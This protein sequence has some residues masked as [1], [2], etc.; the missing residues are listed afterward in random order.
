[1]QSYVR[2]RHPP[3]CD[4]IHKRVSVKGGRP[5]F[6]HIDVVK[7]IVLI[8][9][10]RSSLSASRSILFVGMARDRFALV[11]LLVTTQIRHNREVSTATFNIA[12][13]W[14]FTSM[15]VHMGLE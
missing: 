2:N 11:N 9:I 14:L 15:T 8:V 1:M 7:Q 4:M 3:E 6:P 12:G 13:K 5:Q 10:D